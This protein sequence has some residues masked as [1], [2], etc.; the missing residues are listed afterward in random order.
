MKLEKT[1]KEKDAR[2]GYELLRILRRDLRWEVSRLCLD[3]FRNSGFLFL[4][5]VEDS[6]LGVFFFFCSFWG[7]LT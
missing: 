4:L 6:K 1:Q 7:R 2:L 3:I 5:R